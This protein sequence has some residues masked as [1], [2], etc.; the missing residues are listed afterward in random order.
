MDVVNRTLIGG[1]DDVANDSSTT[2]DLSLVR[3]DDVEHATLARE[4]LSHSLIRTLCRTV[5][6]RWRRE[7]TFAYFHVSAADRLSGM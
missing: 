4:S 5:A 7:Y 1:T 6:P 2:N 3:C